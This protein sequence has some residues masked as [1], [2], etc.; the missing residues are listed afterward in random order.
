MGALFR[1]CPPPYMSIRFHP[2]ALGL[3][4][5]SAG[6]LTNHAEV[7]EQIE[8]L[9]QYFFQPHQCQQARFHI[10]L[11]ECTL[12]Y[13]VLGNL[14]RQNHIHRLAWTIPGQGDVFQVVDP[15]KVRKVLW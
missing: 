4:A 9:L 13:F 15:S 7:G 8:L 10:L 14:A 6:I 2:I 11:I 3:S 1:I 5:M 12:L